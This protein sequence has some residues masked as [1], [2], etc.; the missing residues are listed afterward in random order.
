MP[1]TTLL[2]RIALPL[3]LALLT[4]GCGDDSD[5]DQR[6]DTIDDPT[7]TTQADEPADTTT[8][9]D[10]AVDDEQQQS[11]ESKLLTVEDMPS[12]YTLSSS[13]DTDDDDETDDF[14][15]GAFDQFDQLEGFE[16][17]AEA[18][19]EFQKGQPTMAGGAFVTQS[20]GVGDGDRLAEAF[21]RLPSAFEQCV[22]FSTTEDDGTT[23]SGSFSPLSFASFGD[24]T[25]ATHVSGEVS[26]QGLT[27]AL[28]GD[29]VFVREGDIAMMVFAFSFG[30]VTVP[31]EEL[32]RIVAAA[33]AK[34]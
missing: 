30:E 12:G 20:L 13:D 24:D 32:E 17:D 31:A 29:M 15:E 6:A 3:A 25:F 34:L 26:G 14:C 22:A 18:E 11:L 23:V 1:R 27:F 21:E 7:S 16:D 2:R 19:V 5:D 10:S 28:S 33:H 8:T 9:E 4:T